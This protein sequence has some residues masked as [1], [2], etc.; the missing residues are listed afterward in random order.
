MTRPEAT[1]PAEVVGLDRHETRLAAA[2]RGSSPVLPAAD[3]VAAVEAGMLA[4]ARDMATSRTVG[5]LGI[6][7]STVRVHKH[8]AVK[9]LRA[10]AFPLIHYDINETDSHERGQGRRAV[11]P[12]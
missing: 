7:E 2:A 10:L 8:H 6:A 1:S 9:A 11:R 3:A 5:A 12:R 4:D